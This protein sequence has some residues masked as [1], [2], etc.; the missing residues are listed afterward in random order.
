MAFTRAFGFPPTPV[1]QETVTLFVA[2]LGAEGLS[3]S[4]IESY[5]AALRYFRIMADPSCTLPSFHT[6]HMKILL[7]GIQ[8]LHSQ[9]SGARHRLP[10][11]V[12]LMTRIKLHLAQ[13]PS[14]H[15]NRMLWA[16]CCTGFFGFLRCSEF[17]LPDQGLFNPAC[18]LSITDIELRQS[19]SP[20]Y[21][22][23]TIKYSKTDQFGQGAQVILGATGSPVCSVATLLDF[24]AVRGNDPGPLFVWQDSTPLR[25]SAFVHHIQSA[26][27][28]SGLQGS[29]FNG[30]SFRIG[31]ATSA[32]VAGV[33]EST[34]KIL[35]RWK[36]LAYQRYVR[37]ANSDLS[38]VSRQL[39][40]TPPRVQ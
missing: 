2:Y 9:P 8:Q 17:L 26:L 20:W 32:S 35:G 34:I 29:N 23:L 11:T 22:M 4:T 5:L 33:P 13:D 40:Q 25:R 18:H 27:A 1:T 39:V 3:V 12:S 36:S 7:R 38:L 16:A 30:H 28:A 14:S 6:P 24:L 15:P 37:P 31:A 19:A 10:I 21:F